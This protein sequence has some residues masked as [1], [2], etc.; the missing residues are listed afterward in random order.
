MKGKNFVP[1]FEFTGHKG[2]SADELAA[3]LRALDALNV[4][5]WQ[6]EAEKLRSQAKGKLDAGIK[7]IFY[8]R[9]LPA[10]EMSDY[11]CALPYTLV[12]SIFESAL[13]D[14]D[15]VIDLL[16]EAVEILKK[17]MNLCDNAK[18][19]MRKLLK[20]CQVLGCVGYF[21]FGEWEDFRNDVNTT[22]NESQLIEPPKIIKVFIDEGQL[23]PNPV[24]GQYKPF[25]NVRQFI[26][27]CVDNNYEDDI[28]VNFILYYINHEGVDEKS[29]REYIAE[30][31][32]QKKIHNKI[33]INS[34]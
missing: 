29:I 22:V 27:W 30:A 32:R 18:K 25:K 2:M 1:T 21:D 28:S 8:I 10:D 17:N 31:K 19:A 33:M 16:T 26:F 7:E 20:V 9:L 34:Q 6:T 3:D 24:N 14:E 23:E 12:E 11:I 5:P 13:N 4:K 15:G